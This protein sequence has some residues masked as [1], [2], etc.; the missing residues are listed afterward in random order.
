MARHTT[1][2]FRLLLRFA[3]EGLVRQP[4]R[5][6]LTM[7]SMAV[8][9]T[10]V[11]AVVSIGLVG[12]H[13]V[14]GLIEGVGANLVIAYGTGDGINPE[15]IAFDDVNVFAE[16]VPEIRDLAPVVG[17][18]DTLYIRGSAQPVSV[19]GVTPAYERVRNLVMVRGRFLTEQE[20]AGAAKVCVISRELAERLFGRPEVEDEWLRLF[21]LRFR[22]VGMYREGVESAAAVGKSEAAGLVAMVPLS[23]LRNLSDARFVDVLYV[24]AAS[25]DA[26]DS[27]KRGI[28]KVIASRH[29]SLASF[30]IESLDRYLVL[31][32]QIF[33]AVTLGLM[34]IATVS[35]L[36]GGIGIMNIMLVTVTERT[37]DVG[38]RLAL[39]AGRRAVLFQFLLEASILSLS[40]GILG[41]V[42]GAGLP[43]Y[44]GFL[45]NID[46]PISLPS[47]VVAFSVSVG[48]GLFFGIYPARK[49]ANMNI[50]DALGWDH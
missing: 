47:M 2:W 9:T 26:V 19:L 50:V 48:V 12:R 32:Q 11:V 46:V 8:G 6:L 43:A 45:Y 36:V 30:K 10:S 16:E 37:S 17:S 5:S 41:V 38:I 35:L 44:V 29:R 3:V 18:S 23:T 27:V 39:G 28:A 49:A 33:N 31:A 4:G 24:Q 13:Y 15:E 42:V 7:L 1:A 14:V 40:G 21:N 20:E 22:I 34:A 25:R